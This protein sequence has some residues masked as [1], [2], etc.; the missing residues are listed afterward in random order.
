MQCSSKAIF[1]DAS[2][3][4]CP[5]PVLKLRKALSGIA[6]GG[7]VKVRATD[8]GAQKEPPRINS[9]RPGEPRN[10]RAATC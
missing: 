9:T 6:P 5:M 8:P 10:K 2:G 4:T 1:I 7:L 3:L